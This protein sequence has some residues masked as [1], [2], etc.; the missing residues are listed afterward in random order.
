ML[1]NYDAMGVLKNSFFGVECSVVWMLVSLRG[2]VQEPTNLKPLI[3]KSTL[4]TIKL[5]SFGL[6]IQECKTQYPKYTKCI[7]F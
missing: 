3:L 6:K 4:E 2:I 7:D 5:S 1:L